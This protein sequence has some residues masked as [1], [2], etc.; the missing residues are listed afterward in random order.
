MVVVTGGAGLLGL[1]H[2]KA[3]AMAG[4]IPIIVDNNQ[5]ALSSAEA[6]LRKLGLKHLAILSDLTV[7]A[8]E[9]RILS[10]AI[11][12]GLMPTALINN[13]ASNPPMTQKSS[14]QGQFDFLTEDG[15]QRWRLDL[16][17]GLGV[18]ARMSYG[19][20][21]YFASRGG[22]VIINVASD[23]AFISPDQRVYRSQVEEFNGNKAAHPFKPLS[24]SV[25]KSGLLGLTR[26]FAT[27]WAPIPVRVN[28]IAPGSVLD[29]QS[30]SLIHNLKARIPLERLAQKDEYG[31]AI[32]FLLSRAS[33]YMTGSVL[34]MD[35]GRTAW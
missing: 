30:D 34:V 12:S 27:L 26:Y 24:Y 29:K 7:E 5:N 31:G 35:G 9:E 32:I 15:R 16:E 11:D 25:V 33:S 17:L 1:E 2:A 13:L 21:E 20:G 3:I 6:D 4:G 8:S 14:Q 18:A 28:A 23:L 22:G 19:F 10:I